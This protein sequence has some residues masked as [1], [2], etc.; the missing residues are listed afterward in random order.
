M[1]KFSKR[2]VRGK[3]VM[4]LNTWDSNQENP[5]LCAESTEQIIN[6]IKKHFPSDDYIGTRKVVVIRFGHIPLSENTER[7]KKKIYIK[8]IRESLEPAKKK[9]WTPYKKPLELQLE[10]IFFL[11]SDYEGRDIDNMLRPFLNALEGEVFENDA[12]I[13]RIVAEKFLVTDIKEGIDKRIYEQIYCVISP[14]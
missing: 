2:K 10:V 11:T 9:G 3:D 12:Q 14:F 7:K 6:K 4:M 13:R 8:N 1:E 5:H